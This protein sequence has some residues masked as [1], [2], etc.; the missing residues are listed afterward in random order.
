MICPPF[1]SCLTTKKTFIKH[2]HITRQNELGGFCFHLPALQFFLNEFSLLEKQI[3]EHKYSKKDTF[4]EDALLEKC[5]TDNQVDIEKYRDEYYNV[6]FEGSEKPCEEY[7]SGLHWVLNYYTIGV[8]HWKWY[9]K[10][11]YAPFA[12]D[13]S[14]YIEKFKF[15]SP[16]YEPSQPILP[17]QQLLCLLPPKSANL[18]PNP[19]SSILSDPSSE[20]KK[21][22]PDTFKIDTSGKRQEWEGIVLIP[23]IDFD[24]VDKLYSRLINQVDENERKRNVHGRSF[25]YKHNSTNKFNFSSPFGSLECKLVISIISF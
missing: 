4:I 5:T 19:L 9:Y 15:I 6:H 20:L 14:Q 16:V 3:L 22:C 8:P 1:L 21:Y 12:Y 17:F 2:G 23:M 11:H 25:S 18:L 24:V 7:L 13:L 10:R